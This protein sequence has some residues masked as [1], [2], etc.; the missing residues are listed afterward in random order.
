MDEEL[1]KLPGG[2][3]VLFSWLILLISTILTYFKKKDED[4][5]SESSE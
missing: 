4:K 2:V 1:K 3:Q 5:E